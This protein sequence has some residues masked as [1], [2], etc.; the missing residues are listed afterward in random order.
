MSYFLSTPS[1]VKRAR[2]A[3]V[4]FAAGCLAWTSLAAS[5]GGLQ[6]SP[7][8]L[9]ISSK[10]RAA[11][12]TLKNN[13]DYPMGAQVR[14][15]KWSQTPD[16]EYVLEP[17]NDLIVSPP[18]VQMAPGLTQEVRVL[19]AGP[20]AANAP[21]SYYRVLVDELPSPNTPVKNGLSLLVR[22]NIP[23][24]V[25]GEL[26]PTVTLNWQ[27]SAKGDKTVF[28]IHNPGTVRAQVGRIWLEKYG[29]KTVSLSNGLTGYVL[30]GQTL[31]REF[32]IAHSQ[33][34]ASGTK[35]Q[36]SINGKVGTVSLSRS[37]ATHKEP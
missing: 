24:F 13:S 18:I 10:E 15:F 23:V 27:A 35:I 8:N 33:L 11:I 36:A 26:W 1:W 37:A 3:F 12:L 29:D 2:R 4:F 21:E 28:S 6:A 31:V 17:S 5:A 22:H 32:P 30:P 19:R 25:N 14:V 20:A 7:I 9:T 34:E 16:D